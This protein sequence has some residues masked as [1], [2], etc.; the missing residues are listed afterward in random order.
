MSSNDPMGR[1]T[2]AEYR[3]LGGLNALPEQVSGNVNKVN[4]GAVDNKKSAKGDSVEIAGKK[5]KNTNV[6]I[7]SIA[8]FT[9]VFGSLFYAAKRGKTINGEDSK[10]ISNIKEGLSSIFTSAGREKYKN[11]LANLQGSSDKTAEQAA[12]G[13][14]SEASGVSDKVEAPAPQEQTGSI[15]KDSAPKDAPT[16][17]STITGHKEEAPAGA[18]SHSQATTEPP[19]ERTESPKRRSKSGKKGSAKRGQR[20]EG[21][22]E[23]RTRRQSGTGEGDKTKR[24]P[25][26]PEMPTGAE[27]AGA[28]KTGE[29]IEPETPVQPRKQV[30]PE[31]PV[32]SGSP[33][34]PPVEPKKTGEPEVQAGAEKT[35]E[36]VEAEKLTQPEPQAQPEKQGAPEPSLEPEVQAGSGK[37]GESAEPEAPV[38]PK[39]Q[40]APEPEPEAPTGAEGA[41]ASAEAE[42]TVKSEPSAEP[43]S[44]KEPPIEPGNSKEAPAEPKK[45][46]APEPPVQAEPS[47]PLVRTELTQEMIDLA[48]T[49]KISALADVDARFAQIDDFYSFLGKDTISQYTTAFGQLKLETFSAFSDTVLFDIAADASYGLNTDK[50]AARLLELESNFTPKEIA[51]ICKT[52]PDTLSRWVAQCNTVN[53]TNITL[54]ELKAAAKLPDVE[55]IISDIQ[56]KL[57]SQGLKKEAEIVGQLKPETVSALGY[58][59]MR[60]IFVSKRWCKNDGLTLSKMQ[61]FE[62]LFTPS[63]IEIIGRT[64]DGLGNLKYWL[65]NDKAADFMKLQASCMTDKLPVEKPVEAAAAEAG[66]KIGAN[67]EEALNPKAKQPDT[68]PETPAQPEPPAEPEIQ[69]GAGKTGESIE[70]EAPVQ[71]KKQGAPEPPVQTEEAGAVEEAVQKTGAAA[72]EADK[73]IANKNEA[74]IAAETLLKAEIEEARLQNIKMMEQI[75]DASIEIADFAPLYDIKARLKTYNTPTY[76]NGFETIEQ[77]KPETVSALSDTAVSKILL[78][79][80]IKPEGPAGILERLLKLE[81]EFTPSEISNICKTNNGTSALVSWLKGQDTSADQITALKALTKT[82]DLKTRIN[83]LLLPDVQF[84]DDNYVP[85]TIEKATEALE[86]LKP[87]TIAALSDETLEAVFKYNV[88]MATEGNTLPEKLLRLEEQFTPDELSNL[89][90]TNEGSYVLHQWIQSGNKLDGL[91]EKVKIFEQTAPEAPK[92]APAAQTAVPVQFRFEPMPLA[93]PEP[94]QEAA[95]KGITPDFT[96]FLDAINK[97]PHRPL[98]D[99]EVLKALATGKVPEKAKGALDTGAE[100][101]QEAAE[102]AAE[103]IALNQRAVT[104]R[105]KYQKLTGKALD[106]DSKN[107]EALSKLRP[108][109]VEALSDNVIIK[110]L[111]ASNVSDEG[112]TIA[113]RLLKL[114]EELSADEIKNLCKTQSG[115]EA[116]DAWVKNRLTQEGFETLRTRSSSEYVKKVKSEAAARKEAAAKTPETVNAEPLADKSI[117][118]VSGD[119]ETPAVKQTE[120][121]ADK[122][123][124]TGTD[125]GTAGIDKGTEAAA[126]AKPATEADEVSKMQPGQFLSDEIISAASEAGIVSLEDIEARYDKIFSKYDFSEDTKTSVMEAFGQIKPETASALN[127]YAL[128][129]IAWYSDRA[130]YLNKANASAYTLYSNLSILESN[131]TPQEIANICKADSHKLGDWLSGESHFYIKGITN[132]NIEDITSLK[133]IAQTPSAQQVVEG[134]TKVLPLGPKTIADLEQMKPE[135][136]VAIGQGALH[137][138]AVE[139]NFHKGISLDRIRELEQTFSAA[140]IETICKTNEGV[141]VLK[142]WLTGRDE[143]SLE[144]LK[145]F[146]VLPTNLDLRIATLNTPMVQAFRPMQ[147]ANIEALKRLRPATVAAIDDKTLTDI[148]SCQICSTKHETLSSRLL[149]VEEEFSADEISKLCETKDGREFL[150]NWATFGTEEDFTAMKTFGMPKPEMEPAVEYIQTKKKKW[151]LGKILY[152]RKQHSKVDSARE[153][154]IKI[155]ANKGEIYQDSPDIIKALKQLQPETLEQLDEYSLAELIKIGANG[156]AM[157]QSDVSERLL[158]LESNFTPDEIMNLCQTQ[159]GR[160]DLLEWFTCSGSIGDLK[161]HCTDHF[162][163]TIELITEIAQDVAQKAPGDLTDESYC[164]YL[165]QTFNNQVMH[166]PKFSRYNLGFMPY[167]KLE[168]EIRRVLEEISAS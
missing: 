151:G 105:G 101:L 165:C 141:D 133:A 139:A 38:Q 116:I 32:E 12:K 142:K 71:P 155:A 149:R 136:I 61:E 57:L 111:G 122:G 9:A 120:A 138:I 25:V 42:K 84:Y 94:K 19:A 132:F 95:Q 106:I 104:L 51:N 1:M 159:T 54:E 112:G 135:T 23:P 107:T 81:S 44:P 78:E 55:L 134:V 14:P 150:F 86:Q 156:A 65:N 90:R 7:A 91:K 146:S 40:G 11:A 158:A 27:K 77:L 123:L 34:E 2:F 22:S 52:D 43:E 29:P 145:L 73:T 37:T 102:A 88:N 59:G 140:Q 154:V 166:H 99:I 50:L 129:Q 128:Y 152:A 117:T 157:K 137:D 53:K 121:A 124:E 113:S 74:N 98:I 147:T 96:Q 89:C 3:K 60:N 127:D 160:E 131:F 119:M 110:I 75:A 63:E 92:A 103:S 49:A 163:N 79:Y 148:A 64:N 126:G 20:T 46:G 62:Q 69:A 13:A 68:P 30:A 167:H 162:M 144:M 109:T 4:N 24:P 66:Q 39:K 47:A 15:A 108:E 87:E 115:V 45:A 70:P 31:P 93:L 16:G 97:A 26:E 18:N 17:D 100:K 168:N 6:L 36:S 41:G 130:K 56:E 153:H 143:A 80:Y 125:K 72:A 35:G 118:E 28:G 48:H 33:K 10:L 67:P 5:N 8:A 85:I 58:D 114:E 83:N 164:K 21:E 161:L 76:T 82:P